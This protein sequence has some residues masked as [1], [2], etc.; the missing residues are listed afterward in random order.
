MKFT[1]ISPDAFQSIQLNAG[2]L[3]S[4]F[5]PESGDLEASNI[6]GATS[7]GVN[8]TA[9]PTMT[10]FGEDID[11]VPANTKELKR[12]T[13]YAVAMSGT[14]ITLT[15]AQVKLLIG[16][17]D[18]DGTKITPRHEL[19]SE[20]FTDLWWV[21][22]YSDKNSEESGGFIAIHMKNSLSTGGFSIQSGKNAKGTSAFTFTGH[23]SIENID[24]VPFEVFVKVGA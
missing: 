2:V 8:F 15:E 22:D 12:V 10:D 21:G 1:K 7:G 24:E 18:V 19:K 5:E 14:F 17:A 23:Y 20:D 16:A 11:N 6:I 4:S 3:L 13:D 9:T